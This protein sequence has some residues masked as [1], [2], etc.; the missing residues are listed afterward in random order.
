MSKKK[1]LFNI[2]SLEEIYYLCIH[3]AVTF[4]ACLYTGVEE[5][6]ARHDF[7]VYGLSPRAPNINSPSD[8]NTKLFGL[9]LKTNEYPHAAQK[10]IE[11]IHCTRKVLNTN[12]HMIFKY[13]K[14]YKLVQLISAHSFNNSRTQQHKWTFQIS[15]MM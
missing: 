1:K 5:I 15:W 2:F 12:L 13:C 8:W 3:C 4:S 11:L 14:C 6:A 9:A 7:F 10:R